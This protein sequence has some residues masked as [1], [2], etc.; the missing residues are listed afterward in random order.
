MGT[1]KHATEKVSKARGVPHPGMRQQKSPL[2]AASHCSQIALKHTEHCCLERARGRGMP[3]L[4][5]AGRQPGY[6]HDRRHAIRTA[7][8]PYAAHVISQ[9]LHAKLVCAFAVRNAALG[10]D[11]LYA[12]QLHFDCGRYPTKLDVDPLDER[13]VLGFIE[14]IPNA[15]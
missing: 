5:R 14:R 10:V 9:R 13:R 8:D 12:S 7:L 3:V 4:E 6:V 1:R 11:Y 15:A 2:G